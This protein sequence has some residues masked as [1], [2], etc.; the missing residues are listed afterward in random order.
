MLTRFGCMEEDRFSRVRATITFV[1]L[2]SLIAAQAI[3]AYWVSI[4][5]V[6]EMKMRGFNRVF[7]FMAFWNVGGCIPSLPLAAYIVAAFL[8]VVLKQALVS[9]SI[10]A[11]ISALMNWLYQLSILKRRMSKATILLWRGTWMGYMAMALGIIAQFLIFTRYVSP[12][13]MRW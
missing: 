2:E 1:V 6:T 4:F 13:S 9:N 5:T 3:W 10:G 7:H 12:I 8:S 11:V